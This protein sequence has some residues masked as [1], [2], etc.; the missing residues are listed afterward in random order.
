MPAE[1]VVAPE[2]RVPESGM[3]SEADDLA[4]LGMAVPGYAVLALLG[5]GG[6]GVVYK[7]RHLALG[8]TVALKMIL[9][10]EHASEDERRRFQGEAQAVASLQHA[11]IVQIFEVGQH[12]GLPYFSLEFCPG[13]GLEKQL[14]GT[15]W[16]AKRAAALVETLARA[17]QA[18]HQKGLV[19]RDLK[20]ANVLLAEDGT[21]KVT[22]FG[23]AKKIDARGATQTGAVVGTPSYM[24]PEQAS[25]R[26]DIGPAADVYALGAILYELLTGRPP[27]RG[28]TTLDTLL[29]VL[30][31]FPE[32]PRAFN[33]AVNA[34]LEAICLR[35]LEKDPRDRYPTALALAEDLAA[36]RRGDAVLAEGPSNLRLMRLLLQESR[37]TEVFRL[38]GRIWQWHAGIVFAT[39]AVTNMLLWFR[40]SRAEPYAICWAA[41][42]LALN[43]PIWL[44]RLR[45]GPPFTRLERQ[46]SEVW[47]LCSLGSLL[48]GGFWA[49]LDI[50]WMNL[51]PVVVLQCGVAI[52]CISV[53]W[54]G[55]FRLLAVIVAV[56]TFVLVLAPDVGPLLFGAVFGVA[57]YNIGRKFARGQPASAIE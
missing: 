21:P 26:K 2:T 14:D 51:L 55:T 3:R 6:M 43:V 45:E 39:F 47:C 27:F 29:Q 12:K 54:G 17:M 23:L 36:Y 46:A 24:A 44:F 31:R 20:P 41:G 13:G 37:H 11:N 35:S 25:G 49:L 52:G 53:I 34:A 1:A 4:P 38:W 48:T 15:P 28:D 5:K 10:A 16:E 18:A 30:E 19:H 7:A 42:L 22:D 40:V 56:M 9:H 8:R 50:P 33:P 57:L 32:R